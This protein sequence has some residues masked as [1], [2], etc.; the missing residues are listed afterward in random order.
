MNRDQVW[1][2][3]KNDNSKMY[4]QPMLDV[5]LQVT[6]SLSEK[7]FLELSKTQI[8]KLNGDVLYGLLY[9]AG[10]IKK[11]ADLISQNINKISEH[12]VYE[13]L[14]KDNR[15]IGQRT[16]GNYL[17]RDA[18]L[19]YKNINN[20]RDIYSLIYYCSHT[21][22][23]LRDLLEKIGQ[24]KLKYLEPRTMHRLLKHFLSFGENAEAF[25]LFAKSLKEN[26]NKLPK[27]GIAELIPAQKP[28]QDQKDL[29]RLEKVVKLLGSEN[30]NKLQ[31]NDIK[32]LLNYGSLEF[33]KKLGELLGD[34]RDR[35]SDNSIDQILDHIFVSRFNDHLALAKMVDVIGEKRAL[36]FFNS[37]QGN[38]TIEEMKRGINIAKEELIKNKESWKRNSLQNSLNIKEQMLNSLE[39]R[40]EKLGVKN[41]I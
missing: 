10:D 21:I 5:F 15:E 27:D 20:D 22:D 38:K 34:I 19:Q 17:R 24:D 9:Y 35:L 40:I 13:L 1:E 36:K 14:K 16:A 26:I 32:N 41:E 11:I 39:E 12:H 3:I 37:T 2:K 29:V 8:E 18:I 7:H 6:D 31:D 23:A 25:E 33:L 4:G 28:N 30:L